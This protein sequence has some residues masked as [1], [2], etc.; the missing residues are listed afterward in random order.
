MS[1]NV[2]LNILIFSEPCKTL[3]KSQQRV[4]FV[5]CA[6]RQS[7]ARR[8]L[9]WSNLCGDSPEASLITLRAQ[10]TFYEP[11]AG[12]HTQI[13]PVSQHSHTRTQ[14]EHI[15]TEKTHTHTYT[16]NL[17]SIHR[18]NTNKHTRTH[19]DTQ[20]HRETHTWRQRTITRTQMHTRR[21][22]HMHT[23]THTETN[24]HTWTHACA[25]RRPSDSN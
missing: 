17:Y 13:S 18:G 10:L 21:Q 16:L 6:V 5:M 23:D 8:S 24:T 15:F 12:I 4:V 14:N 9:M 7:K 19:I 1:V 20:I 3:C 22:T 2:F 11:S 25:P